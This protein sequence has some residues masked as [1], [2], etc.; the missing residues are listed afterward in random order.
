MRERIDWSEVPIVFIKAPP[1]AQCQACGSLSTP[2]IV[3]SEQGGDG[4]VS[5]RAIC[6]ECSEP[7]LIVVEPADDPE[8]PAAGNVTTRTV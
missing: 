6:R 2:T 3:R 4:S 1:R 8:F 7:F 5:R